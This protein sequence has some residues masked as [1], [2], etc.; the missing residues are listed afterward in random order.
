MVVDINGTKAPNEFGKD[1]FIFGIDTSKGTLYVQ[2]TSSIELC[3][4]S[5]NF[6]GALIYNNG[7]KVPEDY[8]IRL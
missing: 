6:C 7:W 4:N 2:G 5:T 3:K 1:V 8:P